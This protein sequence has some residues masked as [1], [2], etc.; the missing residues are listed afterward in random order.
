MK[1]PL[2]L[3][4][5][6]YGTAKSTAEEIARQTGADLAEIE[7][8]VPYDGD[9]NHYNALARLAKREHDEDQRPAIKNDLPIADYDTVFIGSGDGQTD[10]NAGRREALYRDR[11]LHPVRRL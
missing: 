1:K 7:P 6:V 5:S 10:F 2:V 9:R 11:R 3:Y 4:F 8:A